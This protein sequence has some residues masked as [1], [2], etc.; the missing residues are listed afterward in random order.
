MSCRSTITKCDNTQC[1]NTQCDNAQCD[2]AQCDNAQCDNTQCDSVMQNSVTTHS[3][4]ETSQHDITH[5][6]KNMM[7]ETNTLAFW[8]EKFAQYKRAR[9]L[10]KNAVFLLQKLSILA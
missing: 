9:F 8:Q 4:C 5:W 7:T 6:L 3:Y 1:D 10:A 2:N